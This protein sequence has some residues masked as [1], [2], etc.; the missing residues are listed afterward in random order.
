LAVTEGGEMIAAVW[1]NGNTELGVKINAKDRDQFF[2]KEW[3]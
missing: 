3:S 1:T 2:N